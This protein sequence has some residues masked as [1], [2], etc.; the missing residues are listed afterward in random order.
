VVAVLPPTSPVEEPVVV[1][2]TTPV[3]E[4]TP[5][6]EEPSPSPA[7]AEPT[8]ET[9]LS[10]CPPPPTPVVKT[11]EQKSRDLFKDD[12]IAR[13][14]DYQCVGDVV[15]A[16]ST[17][18]KTRTVNGA[19]I[20]YFELHLKTSAT[21]T[22]LSFAKE[23]NLS[24]S[25]PALSDNALIGHALYVEDKGVDNIVIHVTYTTHGQ[26]CA[27]P[28]EHI[29]CNNGYFFPMYTS[30][31]PDLVW[32]VPVQLDTNG[33]IPNGW[34]GGGGLLFVES[35]VGIQAWVFEGGSAGLAITNQDGYFLVYVSSPV[36]DPSEPRYLRFTGIG[37]TDGRLWVTFTGYIKSGEDFIL[38][39]YIVYSSDK[40]NTWTFPVVVP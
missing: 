39:E 15:Y 14:G 40:G 24:K 20:D 31:S 9:D 36:Y 13:M 5:P 17:T 28:N 2:T 22:D 10:L 25:N 19:E 37:F 1:A 30:L 3:V 33:H 12:L 7:P 16:M 6:T 29:W 27:S 34:T 38:G 35:S 26:Q 4:P 23:P 8:C 18:N 32:S 21:T 11:C